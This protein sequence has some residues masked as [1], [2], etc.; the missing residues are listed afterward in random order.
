M[1]VG[2]QTVV[3]PFGSSWKYLA[4]GPDQGT[5]WRASGFNDTSWASGAGDLGFK[6]ANHTVIP[7]TTNRVTYYFRTHVTLGPATRCR[8]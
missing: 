4:T 8:P 3:L 5:A 6:N 2:T 1:A 7:A